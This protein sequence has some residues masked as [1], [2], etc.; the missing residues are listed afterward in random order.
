MRGKRP[1]QD[2]LVDLAALL[3]RRPELDGIGYT[4]ILAERVAT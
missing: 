4:S 1:P 3:E 2:W